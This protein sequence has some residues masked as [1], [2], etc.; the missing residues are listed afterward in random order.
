MHTFAEGNVAALFFN[1]WLNVAAIRSNLCPN[2]TDPPFATEP[3][4][5]PAGPVH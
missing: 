4:Q 1:M 2:P 3:D 5:Y